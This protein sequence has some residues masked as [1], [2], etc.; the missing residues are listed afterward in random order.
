MLDLFKDLSSNLL[1][2]SG[3]NACQ[4][5]RNQLQ[6]GKLGLNSD[7]VIISVY[8]IIYA[9]NLSQSFQ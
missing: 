9:D 7:C 4:K 3:M 8:M 2:S 1:N 6:G 5:K